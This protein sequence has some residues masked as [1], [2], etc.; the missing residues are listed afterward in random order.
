MNL[1]LAASPAELFAEGAEPFINQLMKGF[2]LSAR[3]NVWR[4][5]SDVIMKIIESGDIDSSM[6]PI[7]GGLAPVFMLRLNARL[8]ITIDEYM[9]QKLQENPLI[10][11]LLMDALTLVEATSGISNGEEE[12][13]QHLANLTLP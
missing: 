12:F 4:K 6:L 1:R 7:F 2:S 5:L 8:D 9:Q 11:P 10:G 13:S 3:L